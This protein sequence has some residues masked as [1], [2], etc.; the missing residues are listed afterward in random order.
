MPGS[1]ELPSA[2]TT[3]HQAAKSTLT[4]SSRL[5]NSEGSSENVR[6]FGSTSTFN[7]FSQRTRGEGWQALPDSDQ[8]CY[9]EMTPRRSVSSDDGKVDVQGRDGDSKPQVGDEEFGG[10]EARERLEK[11]LVRKLDLRMSIL[12]VIYILN[13]VSSLILSLS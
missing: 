1:S 10:T 4:P 6:D 2:V 12:I 11:N 8:D 3:W 9:A 5:I 13:Y 7:H